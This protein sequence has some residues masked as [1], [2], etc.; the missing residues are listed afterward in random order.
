[1]NNNR[2]WHYFHV[3]RG[4]RFHNAGHMTYVG[5]ID[6]CDLECKATEELFLRERDNTGRFV[7]TYIDDGSNEVISKRELDQGI[8]NGRLC[9]SFDGQYDSDVFVR[10]DELSDIEKGHV[11]NEPYPS[12]I[13]RIIRRY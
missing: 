13:S 6:E 1:M 10:E 5:T 7:Y 11:E 9:V 4:G 8:K 2:I 3:G 12:D